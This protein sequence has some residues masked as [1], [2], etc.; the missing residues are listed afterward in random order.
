MPAMVIFIETERICPILISDAFLTTD[1][2][3][4]SGE[5]LRHYMKVLKDR[6]YTYGERWGPHDIE[7][8]EFA[9]NV[10]SCKELACKG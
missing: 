7:N 6:G 8:R 1:Y 4:N 10:K 5:G 9:A 2:Y 3:E